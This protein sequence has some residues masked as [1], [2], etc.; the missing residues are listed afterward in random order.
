MA[1]ASLLNGF[2]APTAAFVL[3]GTLLWS[4]LLSSAS[5][6]FATLAKKPPGAGFSSR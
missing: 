1:F 6:M 4:I 3:V 2:D 5:L